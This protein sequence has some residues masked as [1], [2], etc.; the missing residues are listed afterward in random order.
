MNYLFSDTKYCI[1]QAVTIPLTIAGF[2]GGVMTFGGME[3]DPTKPIFVR[4]QLN[5]IC[6]FTSTHLC[7][8]T[9]SKEY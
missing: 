7:V 8:R 2:A 6:V 9:S 5:F 1:P 4:W 3:M